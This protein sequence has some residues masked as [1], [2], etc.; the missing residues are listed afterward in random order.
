MQSL[1][2]IQVT[3][4]FEK[5]K[6]CDNRTRETTSNHHDREEEEEEEK[7]ETNFV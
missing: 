2:I 4:F 3:F 1:H 6:V 5:V 7:E